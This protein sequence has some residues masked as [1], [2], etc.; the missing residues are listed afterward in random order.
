MIKEAKTFLTGFLQLKMNPFLLTL[1]LAICISER[2]GNSNVV[3]YLLDLADF[4]SI[5]NF[6]KEVLHK[7]SRLDILINNA[8]MLDC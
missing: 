5:R 3:Y 8:G 1:F 6:A 4:E 7:E 2:S